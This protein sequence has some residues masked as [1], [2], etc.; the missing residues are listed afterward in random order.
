MAPGI[1][2]P[3]RSLTSMRWSKRTP[4][5]VA[6]ALSQVHLQAVERRS[7]RQRRTATS[8]NPENLRR[9]RQDR[10]REAATIHTLLGYDVLVEWSTGFL[11]RE[12]SVR[13]TSADFLPP[14]VDPAYLYTVLGAGWGGMANGS[15][16]LWTTGSCSLT[17]RPHVERAPSP[18]P[19][20]GDR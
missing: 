13:A 11:N 10:A 4:E 12:V 19:A 17:R 5:I 16:G 7:G 2:Q 8:D 20:V 6:A 14:G 1:G 18:W 9:G 15:R 3:V